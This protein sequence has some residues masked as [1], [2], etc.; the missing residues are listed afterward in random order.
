MLDP[1]GDLVTALLAAVSPARAY[2]TV[3]LDFADTEW[4]AALNP[5]GKL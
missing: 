5:L 1:K 4:P 2:A 3:L